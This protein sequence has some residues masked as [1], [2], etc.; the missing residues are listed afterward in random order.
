MITF[1]KSPDYM[2]SSLKMGQIAT[3]LP[4]VRILVILRNPSSRAY[5]GKNI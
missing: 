4:S 5:S 2:R 3:L 1:D